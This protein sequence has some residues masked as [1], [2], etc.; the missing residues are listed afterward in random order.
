[1]A[2]AVGSRRRLCSLLLGALFS[3][4]FLRTIVFLTV[5]LTNNKN[6]VA[7]SVRPLLSSSSLLMVS[8]TLS[9]CSCPQSFPH[10][11][12]R[13]DVSSMPLL[14]LS[15]ELSTFSAGNLLIDN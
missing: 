3:V 8:Y 6:S 11:I 4:F 1:M 7:N 14:A 10:V 2:G 9:V 13:L 12:H 5:D 15:I